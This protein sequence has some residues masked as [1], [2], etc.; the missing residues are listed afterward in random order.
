MPWRVKVNQTFVLTI[1]HN[2]RWAGRSVI[3]L[4]LTESILMKRAHWQYLLMIPVLVLLVAACGCSSSLFNFGPSADYPEVGSYEDDGSLATSSLAFSFQKSNISVSVTVPDGLYEAA[5]NAD[6]RAVLRGEW[7]EDDDWI[8]GYYLSFI[9][10]PQM[11]LVYSATADA[12]RA[13]APITSEKTD[14]YLEYLTVYVQSIPYETSPD[15]TEPKFAVETVIETAGDCDDK[16]IL[17][18]GLLSR[19]GYNVSLLYFPADSHMAVGVAAD[20]PGYR[21]SGYLFIEPTNLSLIGIPPETYENG[22]TLT[23]ELFIIPVGD[24]TK[25]Y[26]KADETRR[27]D[28]ASAEARSRAKTDVASLEM[29]ENELEQMNLALDKKNGALVR[30]KQSGDIRGY[31][32][33]VGN[34]NRRVAEYNQLFQEFRTR[35][36]AYLTDVKFANYVATHIYDRPGLSDAVSVWE[37]ERG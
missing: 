14:E 30:L 13:E 33:G 20:E 26:G 37:R 4:Y 31:N 21:D 3:S 36:D 6:K 34:Y 35:Y 8:S 18:A 16:S 32:T 7:N 12:L 10:D 15:E 29:Q 22:K 11:D 24:G 28:R 1:T 27:I 9:T 25:K 19:Q 5:S 17:L 2:Q 23:S